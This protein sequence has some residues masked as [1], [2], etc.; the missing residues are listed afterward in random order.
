MS[1]HKNVAYRPLRGV[2]E[3]YYFT[4]DAVNNKNCYK[5]SLKPVSGHRYEGLFDGNDDGNAWYRDFEHSYLF[6]SPRTDNY[7]EFVKEG[8]ATIYMNPWTTKECKKY[9]DKVGAV[10]PSIQPGLDTHNAWFMRYN[11]VGGKPRLLFSNSLDLKRLVQKV[12]IA[13]PANFEELKTVFQSIE[14]G[15]D[16]DKIKHILFALFRDEK[17]PGGYAI[18]FASGTIKLRSVLD[19]ILRRWMRSIDTV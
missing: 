16:Y 10:W 12:E 15:S 1:E 5:V 17:K 13:I 18:D 3:V 11:L 19:S 8:C 14:T 6:A 9:V 4:W 2:N 7:N